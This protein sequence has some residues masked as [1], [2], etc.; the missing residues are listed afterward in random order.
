MRV[1]TPSAT[2]KDRFIIVDAVGVCERDKTESCTLNRKPSASVKELL[3][4]VAQ[5]GTDADALT[6]LAGRLARIQRDFAPEQLAELSELAG[7]KTLPEIASALLRAVDPD[8][9]KETAKTLPGVVGEPTAKQIEQAAE[10]LAQEAVTPILNAAFRRRILEIR[11]QNDQTIDRH[12]IDDVIFSGFDAS[13][14][15]KAQAKVVDFQKWIVE[16]K[17]ELTALQVLY[18]GTKPLKLALKDLRN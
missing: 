9:Q 15:Q 13:A 17:D 12:S 5:G 10:Q 8:V 4:Y 3:E 7:G 1:V 18:A 2:S 16:H 14:V 11:T 6:T